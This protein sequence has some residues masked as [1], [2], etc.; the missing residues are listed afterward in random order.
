MALMSKRLT[1]QDILL[2]FLLFLGG[3]GIELDE[4]DV[5]M[6]IIGRGGLLSVLLVDFQSL[7][8][9]TE[10]HLP[11]SSYALLPGHEKHLTLI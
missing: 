11:T 4:A 5:A 3:V 7:H 1:G 2:F 6:E 8:L 9:E 10:N